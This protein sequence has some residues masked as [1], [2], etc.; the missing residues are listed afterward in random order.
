[1]ERDGH[2]AGLQQAP[3]L[4]RWEQLRW[5]GGLL[6]QASFDPADLIGEDSDEEM[7]MTKS[8][9][10]RVHRARSEISFDASVWADDDS[11]D[12]GEDDSC[13][14][15]ASFRVQDNGEVEVIGLVNGGPAERS[16]V[17]QVGDVLL[18]VNGVNVRGKDHARILEMVMGPEGSTVTLEVLR[19]GS[20]VLMV[21]VGREWT[22]SMERAA[23][24]GQKSG[25]FDPSEFAGSDSEGSDQVSG[26]RHVCADADSGEFAWESLWRSRECSV[27]PVRC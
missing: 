21:E 23:P 22:R 10:A 18:T 20:T 3:L 4:E 14:I 15:G 5:S 6:H 2:R 12:D 16:G 26:S 13:G 11:D 17:L 1:M 25:E 8:T 19:D 7:M 24:L 9:S 27:L